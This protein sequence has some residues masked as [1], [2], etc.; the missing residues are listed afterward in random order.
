L[1]LGISGAIN[2]LVTCG[3]KNQKIPKYSGGCTPHCLVVEL[4]KRY[5]ERGVLAG[6]VLLA[7]GVGTKKFDQRSREDS[8]DFGRP[9]RQRWASIEATHDRHNVAVA[10]QGGKVI[11]L[12][13]H[14]DAGRVKE[15]LL[16]CLTKRGFDGRLAYVLFAARKAHL[17]P[18]TSHMP[19]ASRQQH[20]GTVVSFEQRHKYRRSPSTFERQQG[21]LTV[22]SRSNAS[23]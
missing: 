17:T 11:Q 9:R 8:V 15:H 6:P 20:L 19:G 12:P 13:H 7:K 10:D 14:R 18:V 2:G 23:E 21:R 5:G 1:T 16:V 3:R 4:E 22:T